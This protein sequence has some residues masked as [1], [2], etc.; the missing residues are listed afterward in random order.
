MLCSWGGETC[1]AVKPAGART[2]SHSAAMSVHFH[3][4][5]WTN[6]SPAAMWP[7]GR[8]VW[9]RVGRGGGP[10]P[11]VGGVSGPFDEQAATQKNGS[12]NE[13][14][15]VTGVLKKRTG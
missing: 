15:E 9:D 7:E 11:V 6:T 14:R 5:R 13:R 3:S 1:T 12:T 4:K 10:P 8:Y 2:F